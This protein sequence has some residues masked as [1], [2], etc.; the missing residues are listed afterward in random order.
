MSAAMGK[1][2]AVAVAV[3]SLLVVAA[4]VFATRVVFF[5]T[6]DDGWWHARLLEASVV[7]GPLAVLLLAG[8]V[9]WA[10]R[11]RWALAA[12]AAPA[13]PAWALLTWAV[14]NIL[15][16]D[17]WV[18]LVLMQMQGVHPFGAGA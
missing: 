1:I 15:A 13:F 5:R 12:L 17:T 16:N 2:R 4:S 14:P 8:S 3:A 6:S 10:V 9:H 18:A 7:V 11:R